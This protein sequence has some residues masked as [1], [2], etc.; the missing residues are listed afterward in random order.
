M[1]FSWKKHV[2]LVMFRIARI[3]R[4]VGSW[5]SIGYR[6]VGLSHMQEV[7][8]IKLQKYTVL[9]MKAQNL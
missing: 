4:Y 2:L 5:A 3:S 8:S 1:D 6:H 9:V 7:F